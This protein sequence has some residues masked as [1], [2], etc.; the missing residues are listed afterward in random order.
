MN[1]SIS[2]LSMTLTPVSSEWTSMLFFAEL[3]KELNIEREKMEE[4]ESSKKSLNKTLR[5]GLNN[6]A[7]ES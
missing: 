3:V 2:V 4:L 7:K 1:I 5:T 6:N